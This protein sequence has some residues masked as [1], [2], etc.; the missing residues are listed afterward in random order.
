M[1]ARFFELVEIRVFEQLPEFFFFNFTQNNFAADESL[2]FRKGFR[3]KG[4]L[5]L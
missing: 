1:I 2:E 4:A 5:G 3:G